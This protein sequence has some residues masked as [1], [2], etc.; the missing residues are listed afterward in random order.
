MPSVKKKKKKKQQQKQ[1]KKHGDPLPYSL[2]FVNLLCPWP[3]IGLHFS[4]WSWGKRSHCG[5]W[6]NCGGISCCLRCPGCHLNTLGSSC[7]GLRDGWLSL[8]RFGRSNGAG[9]LLRW[10]DFGRSSGT[11]LL[12]SW[13]G[14]DRI[15]SARLGLRV[16]SRAHRSWSRGIDKG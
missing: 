3:C 14:W 7:T 8:L 6:S 16:L 13:F 15:S 5:W 1:Q 12:F 9:L 10:F 4:S 2:S 11:R